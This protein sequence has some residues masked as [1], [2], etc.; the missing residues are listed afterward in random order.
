MFKAKKNPYDLFYSSLHNRVSKVLHL[1]VGFMLKLTVL[2]FI[3]ISK[4]QIYYY[5]KD[6]KL[7]FSS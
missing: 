2:Y 6:S 1:N 3:G 4:I 7:Q 5:K